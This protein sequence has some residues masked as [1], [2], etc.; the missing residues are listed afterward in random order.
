[1]TNSQNDSAN[2]F[3][4]AVDERIS[5]YD[6]ETLFDTLEARVAKIPEIASRVARKHWAE[7][8]K[9]QTP[10]RT[11]LLVL[12]I[13]CIVVMYP[14]YW[15]FS[16]NLDLILVFIMLVGILIL[17]PYHLKVLANRFAR[18]WSII[19]SDGELF[20][21]LRDS[22]FMLGYP[23]EMGSADEMVESRF[24]AGFPDVVR[25]IEGYLRKIALPDPYPL[26][27]P[28]GIVV[29]ASTLRNPLGGETHRVYEVEYRGSFVRLFSI[30]VAADESG[31]DVGTGFPF[32]P[33]RAESR[34]RLAENI[35]D[36]I[37][38]RFLAAKILAD[39]RDAAGVPAMPI[40]IESG[41]TINAERVRFNRT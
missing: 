16:R 38:D 11:G 2:G 9:D 18:A 13:L 20:R 36:R 6:N 3:D 28:A 19:S 24:E 8:E 34:D 27:A 17:V 21:F 14:D 22:S 26:D 32:R 4:R 29:P 35:A 37:I 5:E 40:P 7:I 39:L 30:R 33:V 23:V 15:R 25:S 31:C 10:F 1:M 12:A 41:E